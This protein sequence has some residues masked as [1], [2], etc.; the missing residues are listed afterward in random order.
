MNCKA[1]Q[2]SALLAHV[3]DKGNDTIADR[4]ELN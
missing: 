3:A 1:Q 2:V 4:I